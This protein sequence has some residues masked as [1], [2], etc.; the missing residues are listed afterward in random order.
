MRV[1][2]EVGDTRLE[3]QGQV[4]HLPRQTTEVRRRGGPLG[5]GTGISRFA[6]AILSLEGDPSR[7][8]LSLAGVHDEVVV[9]WG[10]TSA[11]FFQAEISVQGGEL[12]EIVIA[13]R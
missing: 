1:A 9:R 2:I 8:V 3:V 12:P 13:E 11:I 10:T 4:E 7:E 6:S 5:T